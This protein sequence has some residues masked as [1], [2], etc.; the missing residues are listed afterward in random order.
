MLR[1]AQH[2]N[3]LHILIHQS[4]CHTELVEVLFQVLII[5]GNPY[6]EILK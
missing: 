6:D 4:I 1:Q 2:D 3:F 5:N